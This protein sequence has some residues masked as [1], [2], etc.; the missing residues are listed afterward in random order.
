MDEIKLHT[1]AIDRRCI[2]DFDW[3]HSAQRDWQF[4]RA[5]ILKYPHREG[6]A[7]KTILIEIRDAN[8][9]FLE[10]QAEREKYYA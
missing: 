2:E 7:G 10:T 9:M 1:A 3:H 8:I 6:L 5:R 4:Y